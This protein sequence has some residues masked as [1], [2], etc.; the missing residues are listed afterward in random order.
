MNWNENIVGIIIKDEVCCSLRYLCVVCITI[1]YDIFKIFGLVLI[2]VLSCAAPGFFFGRYCNVTSHLHTVLPKRN[3]VIRIGLFQNWL[4]YFFVVK[5]EFK[6]ILDFAM[7]TYA[8]P[9]T[10]NRKS[11]HIY[12]D[13]AYIMR[14]GNPSVNYQKN[15]QVCEVDLYNTDKFC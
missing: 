4:C 1:T 8:S 15:M 3:F 12:F 9:S 10:G 2:W 5:M 13:Y 6:L 14:K 11:A 7:A